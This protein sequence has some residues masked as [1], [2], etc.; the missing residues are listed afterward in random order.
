VEIDRF[1]KCGSVKKQSLA[2]WTLVALEKVIKGYQIQN[3]FAV[4]AFDAL[5][6]FPQHPKSFHV[7][8][9]KMVALAV[10][11]VIIIPIPE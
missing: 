3:H 1:S 11:A 2:F 8:V 6:V 4:G 5:R 10:F 7:L 9:W